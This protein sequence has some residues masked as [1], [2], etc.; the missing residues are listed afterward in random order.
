M[1]TQL[2]RTYRSIH[3]LYPITKDDPITWKGKLSLL[4]ETSD[5]IN[6]LLTSLYVYIENHVNDYDF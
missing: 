3:S 5:K 4:V 1:N 6:S 2:A